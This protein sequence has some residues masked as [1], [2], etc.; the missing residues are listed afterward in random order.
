LKR[1]A[2]FLRS[3]IPA[4]PTQLIFLA[5]VVCLFVAPRLRWWPLGLGVASERLTDS[6]AQQAQILGVFFLLPISFT[7]V[8]GYFLC[9]W[10]GSRPLRRILGLICLPAMAGLG[11]MFSR[12]LYLTAPSS[13]V[14]EGVGSLMAQRIRWAW[15]LP[16][17][18]LTGFHFCLIG[19]LLVALYASRLAF[20]IAALPLSLPGNT[21]TTPED[22]GAW[23]RV[24]LLIWVLVGPLYLVSSLLA[25]FTIG[26]P[27]ILSSSVPAYIQS[28]WF[29]RFSPIIEVVAAFALIFWIAGKED[30]HVIWNT[31]ASRARVRRCRAGNSNWNRLA[32]FY[33]TIFV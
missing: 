9:F 3:V 1:F 15:S 16:W 23:R 10:P 19:L 7:G 22:S 4:D 11:L 20:G 25:L 33:R 18:L 6:I 27:M 8:A 29:S 21:V 30:R 26:L 31:P 12:L 13:S 2:E 32:S 17:K 14:L 28:V 24:Q 5:G